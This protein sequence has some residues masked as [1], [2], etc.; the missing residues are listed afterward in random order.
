MKKFNTQRV[1]MESVQYNGLYKA[2][3]NILVYQ[4]TPV[5]KLLIY[6][7]KNRLF[8]RLNNAQTAMECKY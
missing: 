7:I 3:V 4:K 2:Y 1:F 5:S 6:K 8:A